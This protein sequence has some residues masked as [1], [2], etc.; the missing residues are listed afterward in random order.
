MQEAQHGKSSSQPEERVHRHKAEEQLFRE[1]KR[2]E[3]ERQRKLQEEED[4][5][6]RK[7][8]E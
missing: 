8:I 7:A 4:E 1:S 5:M 2:L 3:E 6:L